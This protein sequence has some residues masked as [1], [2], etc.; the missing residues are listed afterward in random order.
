MKYVRNSLAAL[1]AAAAGM[2]FMPAAA[3]GASEG[4]EAAEA[5]GQESAVP[6]PGYALKDGTYPIEAESSSS[7][8]RIVR[9]ELTVK[10]GSMKAAVTLG[11]KGYLKLFMGTGEEALDADPSQYIGFSE[12]ADGA[13]TYELPVEALDQGLE[14]AAF[15]KRKQKWYDRQIVFKGDTLPKEAWVLPAEAGLEDGRYWIDAALS[16]GSGRASVES[17]AELTVKDGQASVRITWSSSAY[18]YMAV[19]GKKYLP[20]SEEGNSAFQIPVYVFDVPMHVAADTTAMGDP[21]E[22]QYTLTFDRSTVRAMKKTA[23]TGFWMAAGALLTGCKAAGGS[24]AGNRLRPLELSSLEYTGRL[25][26]EYAEQFAVDLYQD[27][28]QV[29]TVADGSR[30]LLVPEGKEAPEDVPEETAVVYQPV[31]NI[32]LAASA[33]MDMFR[34][35]DALDT[36]RLS[37][38]DADGW[39]IKEAREAMKSGKILY[40]GKYS[41]PDYERILAEGCGLAVENTMISHAPEVREKLESFGIPVAVD[42]SSYE[43][44]PLGRME[45]IKFYGALTG[46][47]EQASAAFDEQKAA[48]EAA[49]GG[50]EEAASGDG[51]DVDPARRAEGG[52]VPEEGR[53]KTVAYFYITAAGMVNVRKSS[54]YVPKLIEQAG[55]EYIF[56]D[57]GTGESRSSS[58]NMQLE[59]FYSSVKDADFLIYNSA[60]DGGLETV[61][62]LLG[63]SGLLADFKAVKEGNVWCTARDLY[64]SSMALGTFAEDIRAMLTGRGETVYLYRLPAGREEEQ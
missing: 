46:K 13:Y 33:A 37:G 53:K 55:G 58:V 45:W 18:D 4:R 43:T 60:V 54:D 29:L 21:H 32:Y 3:Y 34:A 26:L 49:A 36:I 22:I 39:Y 10:D 15:S 2:V 27:G 24:G 64:Q 31:K 38:T 61:E 47:E 48:M 5:I 40:A 28:F 59:E 8:F 41:A 9:A 11:G 25:E 42:Y 44:E 12:D 56:K 63:K 17:P 1:L 35:L 51:A 14:C 16:G 6:V 23:G 57:L 52:R 7:M 50:S 20:V 62:E 30:M 19:Y